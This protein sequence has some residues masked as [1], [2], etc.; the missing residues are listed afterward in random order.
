MHAPRDF[1][2][3]RADEQGATTEQKNAKIWHLAINKQYKVPFVTFL[4]WL[5]K[6]SYKI[7]FRIQ[8]DN[9]F[10]SIHLQRVPSNIYIKF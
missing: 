6:K 5:I 10:E 8:V 2:V 4:A 7:D 1:L 9:E 3:I